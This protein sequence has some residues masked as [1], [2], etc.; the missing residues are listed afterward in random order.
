[1]KKLE[2][3]V[4]IYWVEKR[5]IFFFELFEFVYR[6]LNL[7]FFERIEFDLVAIEFLMESLK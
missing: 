1:M 2:D 7:I 5:N 4:T 3:I 6:G